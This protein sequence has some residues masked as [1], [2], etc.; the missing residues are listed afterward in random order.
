MQKLILLLL[1]VSCVSGCNKAQ[2]PAASPSSSSSTSS[3]PAAEEAKSDAVQQ[4]LTEFA[5]AGATDCGRLS[6][7][8]DDQLKAAS[9]CAMQAAQA[10]R[11]FF[12]GYDMPGMTVGVAG[13]SDGKLFTVQAQGSANVS[14][15]ACPSQLR[16][17]PSGRVTCFA[18]GD[19]GSMGAGVHNGMSTPG[20][21]MN[22]H[23]GTS[24]SA[25]PKHF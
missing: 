20:G 10:K 9:D 16:V 25:P 12:V 11:A 8:A 19:M 23:M 21:M 1:A 4:K 13:D 5:G 7:Q 2:A 17:A 22:P 18:P 6:S 14:S 3:A 24:T 15:G